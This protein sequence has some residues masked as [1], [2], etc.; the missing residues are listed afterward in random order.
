MCGPWPHPRIAIFTLIHDLITV[1]NRLGRSVYFLCDGHG[2]R[3][4]FG[5]NAVCLIEVPPDEP[6]D[7][8]VAFSRKRVYPSLSALLAEDRGETPSLL[9][10]VGVIH[11][12]QDQLILGSEHQ[13]NSKQYDRTLADYLAARTG[14]R[15]R[16]VRTRYDDLQGN[17]DGFMRLTGIDYIALDRGGREK[18]LRGEVDLR[19][20]VSDHVGRHRDL[21]RSWGWSEAFLDDAI[22]HAWWRLHQLD[23]WR[24]ELTHFDAVVCL[25]PPEVDQNRGLLLCDGAENLTYVPCGSSFAPRSRARVD[26]LLYD[27]HHRQGL[28][29]YRG[30]GAGPEPV[31]FTPDDKKVVFVGRATP[32][33]G[34]YELVESLRNL[35][36][37]GR[38]SVRG[39]LVGNFWPELR[40]ELARIDP[41]QAREYLLFTGP[42]EDLDVLAALW[43]FGD[44][45]AI[46]SHYDPF[47]LVG[48]ESYRMGT[49][50]VVTEGTGAGDAYLANPRRH[51]V[52]IALPVRRRHRDGIMR[53][54]GVDVESLTTQLA[55]LIDHPLVARRLAEDGE[56]FV[57]EHYSAE[58]MGA[59]YSQLYDLLLEGEPAGRLHG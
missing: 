1:L 40:R 33:K 26:Q 44:V 30:A 29:S 4:F 50:C 49:P 19:P 43:A 10:R 6:F 38:R 52:E 8:R 21:M 53:F 32:V 24:Y 15:P 57:R 28:R 56:R 18:I 22:H 59:Q 51:G 17:L 41:E 45:G 46:P 34:I 25:T 23:R 54:C 16:L 47:P 5:P 11:S 12:N 7:W 48:L 35:Y 37:S 3:N 55:F 42:V 13:E 58:R 2:V 14:R 27:Y 20:V 31:A 9:E 36:H 39:I